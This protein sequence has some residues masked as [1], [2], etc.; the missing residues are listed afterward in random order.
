M[1]KTG[2]LASKKFRYGSTATAITVF[3]VALVVLANVIFTALSEKYLWYA[4][5]TEKEVYSLSDATKKYMEEITSPVNI[6]FAAQP[7]EISE[8]TYSEYTKYVYRTA[9]LL[10]QEFD[11]INVECHDVY[12][13][14]NFFKPYAESAATKIAPTSV[15]VES[16]TEFRVMLIDSFFIFD[17]NYQNIWGYTGENK[18]VSAIYQVTASDMPIVC[19]T[20]GHGE[21]SGEKRAIHTMFSDAGF[22]VREIDLSLEDIPADCRIIIADAPLYDFIGR[23][24]E[25]ESANEIAKLDTFLDSYGCFMIF[26]D[27]EKSANLVNLN[28]FL[29][30]WGISFRSNTYLRDYDHATSVDGIT[31]IA[32]YVDKDS[33]ED[34][35]LGASLYADISELDSMPKTVCRYAM[36]VDILWK[37]G[38]GLT[39]TRQ[40]FPVLK[41]YSSSEVRRG[42]ETLSSGSE[43]IMTLS[44][45][46]VIINNEN[47][48][49]YVLACGSASFTSSDYLLSNAYANSEI[50]RS[51]ML[52]MGRERIL[53]DIPY[54]AFDKTDITITTKQANAWTV[55]FTAALPVCISAA[56]VFVYVRRKHS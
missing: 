33:A 35:A 23:E 9:Q 28:E 10:A 13:E 26:A 16:G 39:G 1:K 43:T 54:K 36:P 6:Y 17:D 18:L 38:G 31:V 19:F 30:E 12:R 55:L 14:Y 3:T 5:M 21:T 53:T 37:E 52:A 49:S 11:N 46:K 2:Y 44:R 15:I 51:A 34:G 40:V 20:K 8:G 50:L 25:S 32:E 42:E 24:A 4:D 29:E 41:S 22:D 48:Y 27:Y 47:Y 56:G 7:D 45:D